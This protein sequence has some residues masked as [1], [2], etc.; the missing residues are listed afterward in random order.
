M[1]G[2]IDS[3]ERLKNSSVKKLVDTRANEFRNFDKNNLFS[4]LCFCLMTANFNAKRA[5][6]IQNEIG[7]G[8]LNLS[9]EELARSLQELGH[10]FPNARARY[11]AEARKHADLLDGKSREWLVENVKGL[12]YKE[13][14]HFLRNIG[15]GNC[16][17]IDFHIV[18]LLVRE[19]LMEK[20][21]TLTKKKYLEVETLLGEIASKLN[22][23]LAELDLYLWYLE[24]GTVLK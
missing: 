23:D 17:I 22:L 9:E 8:F 12:G 10:R 15:H 21:K 4:E 16:A 1:Q 14:S 5:I 7:K 3:V 13:A 2:L 24:T 11:I 18:D 20:P 6:A 19:K